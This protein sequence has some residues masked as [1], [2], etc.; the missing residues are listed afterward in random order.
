MDEPSS[1]TRHAPQAVEDLVDAATG[2]DGRAFRTLRD[3]LVRP[4]TM[5]RQAAFEHDPRYVSAVK[6]SLAMSTVSIVLMSWLMPSDGFFERMKAADPEAWAQ[7]QT[8]LVASGVCFA[9]FA[10]RFSNRHELLN[11]VSTLVECGVFAVFVRQLDRTRPFLSHLS[12]VLYCYALWLLVT[13]PLQFVVVADIAGTGLLAGV[14]MLAL[15]PG[16]L[17]MGLRALYPTS[18]LRQVARGV[19]LLALTVVLFGLSMTAISWGAM[20]WTRLSFGM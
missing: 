12:F 19:L 5:I 4:W 1:S 20:L 8:D 6:L 3:L 11:T 10:D 15:M 2:L 7:L 9:H 17:V 14:A 16:L 13:I 18:W